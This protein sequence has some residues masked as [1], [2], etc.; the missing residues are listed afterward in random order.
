MAHQHANHHNYHLRQSIWLAIVTQTRV[1]LVV[2]GQG[3]LLQPV[4]SICK[5]T[6]RV[7]AL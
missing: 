4:C 7:S 2:F 5:T 3:F 6:Q 1:Y